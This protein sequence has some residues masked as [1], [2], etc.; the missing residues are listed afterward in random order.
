MRFCLMWIIII[1]V[2]RCAVFINFPF[3][4]PFY[5]SLFMK[6]ILDLHCLPGPYYILHNRQRGKT[7]SK[8]HSYFLASTFYTICLG[9]NHATIIWYLW[10]G[11]V[12]CYQNCSDKKW[13]KIVLVIE[14]NFWNSR[15]CKNFEIIRTIYSSSERSEQVLVTEC[16]FNLFLEVF[17]Y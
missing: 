15:I 1:L 13:E 7:I 11:M 8:E 2:V 9:K 3:Y 12:F 16:F 10:I 4:G 17:H 5:S 14:K 6:S